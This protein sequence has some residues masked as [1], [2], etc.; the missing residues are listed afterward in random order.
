MRFGFLL[1]IMGL[2]LST[3]AQAA[4]I[5]WAAGIHHGFSLQ[6]GNELPTGCL[7]RIGWFRDPST[8]LQL[9][10]EQIE[11]FKTST[12]DLDLRFVE[13]GRSTI[14]S[15]FVPSIASHF[16]AVATLPESGLGVSLVGKQM[17]LWILNA[18]TLG[19]AT[20]QAI[21][22]W[23]I[24][25][26]VTNPDGTSDTPGTR[27]RFPEQEAFPGST[28]IDLT[29]LTTGTGSLAAGARLLV[30]TYPT[31]TSASSGFANFGLANLYQP[32]VVDTSTV[33]A[34]GSVGVPYKQ[35]LSVIE[36]TPSYVWD[37]TGGELPAGLFMNEEGVISGSPIFAGVFTFIGRARD[38][39]ANTVSREFSLTI[40]SIPLA[41]TSPPLP[42]AGKDAQ[43]ALNLIAEGGTAPYEWSLDSGALPDGITLTSGGL[44]AG[45]PTGSGVASFVV[46]CEDA[47][48][49]MST[50]AF[51]LNVQ[52]LA[53]TTGAKLKNGI[54]GVPYTLPL[55]VIGGKPPYTWSLVGGALPSGQPPGDV[56]N[57][58]GSLN[59][60]PS[61]EEVSMFTLQ[62][63]DSDGSTANRSFTLEV[64]RNRIKPTADTPVFGVVTVGSTFSHMLSGLN[65]PT[66]F[67]ATGLPL[68]LVLNAKTGEIRGRAEIAGLFPVS[69]KV[70]NAAGTSPAVSAN[71]LVEPMPAG[72]IG[73]YIGSIA[74]NIRVNGNLGGRLDLTTTK[75]G[76]YSL[77]LTQGGKAKSY[78]GWLE[79][80]AERNPIVQLGFGTTELHLALDADHDT[81]TGRITETAGGRSDAAVA[82]WRSIWNEST[83][84]ATQY[85][86]FYSMGID[87]ASVPLAETRPVPDGTGYAYAEVQRNGKLRVSGKTA[88]G[89][90]ILSPGFVGPNG[91]VLVHQPLY[92]KLGSMTG[93]L[94]L[95][96]D[97]G[98]GFSE[99][100][101]VGTLTWIKPAA[102]GRTYAN[103]FGPL[104]MLVFGKYLARYQKGWKV[105]GLPE[106][107]LAATLNFAGGGVEVSSTDPNVEFSLTDGQKALVPTPG[108]PDNPGRTVLVIPFVNRTG[109]GVNGLFSGTFR[110][111]DGTR[112]RT[113]RFQGMIIRG[114]D[115]T[116]KA[117]GYFM[118]PQIPN[119]GETVTTSPIL[120]GQVTI[121]Q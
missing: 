43:Y 102:L 82:G 114:P 45:T 117:Y 39:V 88:D 58:A 93:R 56:L 5:N 25:N 69:V 31:G 65:A 54:L 2:A 55:T 61:V 13:A 87:L 106:A 99:N 112:A 48:A 74:H 16:S 84:P 51:T 35:E 100:T 20:E 8:G 116:T 81:L 63:Q 113:V 111:V 115:G 70:A 33:L 118:L 36:G 62:V 10:D 6:N 91:E 38:L 60:T 53:I 1:F 105:S 18:P 37:I 77:K 14:G 12:S 26:T 68:G 95:V 92:S 46:K 110:L 83:K 22:Y 101:L 97:E 47:G 9:T 76:S 52:A 98:G 50:R 66:K 40:A 23:N 71:L 34:G 41:I 7:V 103:G 119:V 17:Y 90:V 27:W 73:T 67:I 75:R 108:G 11:S 96:A 59:F 44:L 3:S 57:P 32:P 64:L 15:G 19:G 94:R 107:N 42:D 85:I 78:S 29:D 21:L 4:T 86:G 104:T 30:G 89:K 121:T 28:T 72:A 79:S 49:L 80:D 24:A 120:S 109:V